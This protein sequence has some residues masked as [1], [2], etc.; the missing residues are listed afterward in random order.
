[1]AYWETKTLAQMSH[2]EWEALCDHCGRCC[3]VKLEDIDS[4]EVVYTAAVC[5]QFDL[6][7]SQCSCYRQRCNRVADCIDLKQH[8]FASYNWLPSTCAYRLLVNG[9]PLPDWH[10]LLSGNAESVQ[11]AGISIS[12]YAIKESQVDDLEDHVIGFL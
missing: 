1:M 7:T 9:Q 8:D 5:E 10:P 6:K 3:L 12:G 2:E 4:G 11:Q